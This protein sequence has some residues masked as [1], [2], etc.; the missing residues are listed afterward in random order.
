[1]ARGHEPQLQAT[2]VPD[3]WERDTMECQLD[4]AVT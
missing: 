4:K 1:M 3:I 2:G